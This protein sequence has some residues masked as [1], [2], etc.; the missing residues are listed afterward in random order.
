MEHH[1]ELHEKVRELEARVAELEVALRRMDRLYAP[2]EDPHNGAIA[3]N[4]EARERE[5]D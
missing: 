1:R 5:A 3:W 4:G 2:H